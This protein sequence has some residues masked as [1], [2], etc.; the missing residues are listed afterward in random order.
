MSRKIDLPIASPHR[1]YKNS[2]CSE[3]GCFMC[4]VKLKQHPIK[5]EDFV[6]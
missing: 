6:V 4:E 5:K 2:E 3:C 1:L